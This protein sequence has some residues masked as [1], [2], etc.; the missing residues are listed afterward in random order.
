L[1]HLAPRAYVATSYWGQTADP[2]LRKALET[3]LIDPTAD[4]AAVLQTA[5]AE[6]QAAL[7]EQLGQ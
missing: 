5:A 1:S 2:A 7:D 4:I 6:A 3:V